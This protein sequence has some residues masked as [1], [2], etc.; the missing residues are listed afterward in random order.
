MEA[1]QEIRFKFIDLLKT[2][3]G[4]TEILQ[5]E[6]GANHCFNI[7]ILSHISC[8]FPNYLTFCQ[9]LV[10][11]E[12][13]FLSKGIT[14]FSSLEGTSFPLK[15]DQDPVFSNDHLFLLVLVYVASLI[16]K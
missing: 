1:I 16:R 12:H 2:T 3:I 15:L 5:W 14:I 6:L 11:Q 8:C 4:F 9:K 10:E 7:Q 13:Q